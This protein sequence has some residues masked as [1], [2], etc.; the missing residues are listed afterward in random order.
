LLIDHDGRLRRGVH[1]STREISASRWSAEMT[2]WPVTL[3]WMLTKNPRPRDVEDAARPPGGQVVEGRDPHAAV[4][5][6]VGV[7]TI[8]ETWPQVVVAPDLGTIAGR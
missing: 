7:V 8:F 6:A 1:H 5:E 3:C 2:P 4:R